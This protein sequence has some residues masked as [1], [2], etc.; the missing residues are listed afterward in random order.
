MNIYNNTMM[1]KKSLLSLSLVFIF[2]GC[3]KE[4]DVADLLIGKWNYSARSYLVG[5]DKREQKEA[6]DCT[7]KSFMELAAGGTFHRESYGDEVPNTGCQL[8]ISDLKSYQYDA[9]SKRLILTGG[10]SK[11]NYKVISISKS[12]LVLQKLDEDGTLPPG[13]LEYTYIR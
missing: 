13:E 4:A 3:K 8:S 7:K 10:K 1:I 11:E 5:V 6:T 9:A 12:K 2:F